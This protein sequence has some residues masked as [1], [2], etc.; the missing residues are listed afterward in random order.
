MAAA[1]DN[2]SIHKNSCAKVRGRG[3]FTAPKERV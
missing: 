1:G 3:I 2:I